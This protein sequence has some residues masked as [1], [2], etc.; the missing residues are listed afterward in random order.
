MHY[1]VPHFIEGECLNKASE[2]HHNIYNPALGKII[3]RVDFA[4]TALCDRAIA[5]AKT[6]NPA[7]ANTPPAKR[8]RILMK[9]RD[10]LER[11]QT[12]LAQLVT[13]EHGK[14]LD[15]AKASIARGIEVVE[16]HTGLVSQL[17]GTYSADVS[18]NIDCYTL[19][20][21]LGICA[22]ISPFNFPIMV[23][24]WMLVP[25]IAC[26]NTF[27][28]KPSE[29]DPSSTLR[30]FEWLHEAGL[31]GGVATCLQGD[32]ST[33]DY[34]LTHPDIAAFTAVASSTV[35]EHI[36]TTA[37]AHGKRAHTFG[38]AKNHAVVMPDADFKQTASAI[39]GAAYGSAGERCMAL[40]VVITVGESTANQLLT[41][42]TPLVNAIKVDAGDAQTCDMGPLISAAHK[43][44]VLT[45]IDA[46]VEEGATLLIDGR[47]F[48]HPDYP[49]GFFVGPTL[50]DHVTE[51][52][53][54]YQE[55]IF[56]PVLI[57][58][59][60]NNFNDAL[61][62]VNRHQYGNGTAIFT[63]SGHA[64]REY[65][66]RVQAGMVGINIPIPV[67]I[68]SHPFGGWKRSAFGDTGMHG[69]E[70][71]RFYTKR[72]TITSRWPEHALDK[73]AFIMSDHTA[74]S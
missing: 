21:P 70:S 5:S 60:V 39:V 18:S 48:K 45:A 49:D 55:E 15:D 14:S 54:I 22:G 28:L 36:Y 64:A 9:F 47:T 2:K 7:W 53:S 25:A 17:Q 34:L 8:A 71:L 56:G 50:F 27:I 67:P 43:E 30:L 65:S 58:L 52:M 20:Q 11:Y 72:K 37:T 61:S 73:N 19:S 40:P 6:A 63:Q 16:Y 68:A 24:I 51:N 42:L 23:P 59:R 13:Q 26:G 1:T 10:Y 66:A 62:L 44:R 32:R 4:D 41:E 3:G 57:L 33:V 35:A 69:I 31:P 29:Q 38:G 12:E 74:L 46:G